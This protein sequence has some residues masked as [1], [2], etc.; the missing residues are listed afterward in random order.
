MRQEYE[1]EAL[2]IQKEVYH[3]FYHQWYLVANFARSDEFF[4]YSYGDQLPF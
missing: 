1:L 2:E 4:I 3:F